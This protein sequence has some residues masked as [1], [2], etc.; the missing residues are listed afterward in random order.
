MQSMALKSNNYI[1]NQSLK[2]GPSYKNVNQLKISRG[3]R[4]STDSP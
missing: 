1:E 3:H 4:D 2:S